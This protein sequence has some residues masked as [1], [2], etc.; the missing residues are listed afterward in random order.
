MINTLFPY[1]FIAFEEGTEDQYSITG[2]DCFGAHLI[3]YEKFQHAGD[4]RYLCVCRLE[5]IWQLH[6]ANFYP[7]A[8]SRNRRY[9][10][11]IAADAVGEELRSGRWFLLLDLS[12]EGHPFI[13]EAF[14]DLHVW[15]ESVG[16]RRDN[17]G[18]LSQ[19]RA[20][21]AAYTAHYGPGG[22]RFFSYDWFINRLS[23]LFATSDADFATI[24]KPPERP[25]A[26][27]DETFA[28]L[29]F[30][31]TPRPARV[32][33]LAALKAAGLLERTLWSLL[34]QAANKPAGGPE[35]VR[36]FLAEIGREGDLMP[37]AL[38]LLNGPERRLDQFEITNANHLTWTI[39]FQSYWRSHVSL[40]T[41][42]DFTAGEIIRVT[43]KTLKAFCMGH[44]A[45]VFGNP[46]SLALVQQCG[47]QT[48]APF[49]S[50]SYDSIIKPAE[51]FSAIFGQIRWIG[52]LLNDPSKAQFLGACAE[53]SRFNAA[54]ARGGGFRRAFIQNITQPCWQ[55]IEAELRRNPADCKT[56]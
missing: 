53:I 54:H 21:G 8:A 50:D 52:H 22:V 47:F 37:H 56:N 26:A 55:A 24:F 14:D 27:Q 2:P 32:A 45:I 42:T 1:R 43:E 7:R 19:N 46:G 36:K 39:D 10:L 49:I 4:Q 33:V 9:L 17:V 48:F 29:C 35:D 12:M 15:C 31:A 40:V 51:R 20:I 5:D 13:Q 41:E 3:P 34:T 18:L 28:F 38:A 30:N 16:M 6:R 11:D 25:P 23:V 44:P